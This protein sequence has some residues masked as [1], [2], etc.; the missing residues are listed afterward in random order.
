ML[1]ISVQLDIRGKNENTLPRD[2]FLMHDPHDNLNGM[3]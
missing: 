2:E 1:H 3:T